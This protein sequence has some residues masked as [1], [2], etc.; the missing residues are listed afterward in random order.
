VNGYDPSNIEAATEDYGQDIK[1]FL[2]NRMKQ[3]GVF[4]L[5]FGVKTNRW[6]QDA[7]SKINEKAGRKKRFPL[8]KNEPFEPNQKL[9]V[10]DT[11]LED[12]EERQFISA[13]FHEAVDEGIQAANPKNREMLVLIYKVCLNQKKVAE[14]MGRAVSGI[15]KN[16]KT[17][18]DRILIPLLHRRLGDRFLG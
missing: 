7:V 3:R 12:T 15:N 11:I 4:F 17:F 8:S 9:T 13:K 6:I 2:L 18:E 10:P 1:V 16:K 14:L 5:E